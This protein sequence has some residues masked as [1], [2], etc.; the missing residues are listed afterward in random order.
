MCEL[1][2]FFAPVLFAKLDV[3]KTGLVSRA[4]FGAF[5]TER[6]AVADS[7]ER[8]FE[9]LRQGQSQ[10]LRQSDFKPLLAALLGSHPGLEFLKD[11]PEFQE[12]YVETVIYRIF[13]GVDRSNTGSVSLRELKRSALLEAMFAVD[14]EEDINKVLKF[15]SYE[16]FYVIY[17]KFWEL[18]TDHDFLIDKDDL[19]RYGNH[20][21][22]YRI[23][24]RIL[25]QAGRPFTSGTE[26]KMGY[27]DFVW[28][29]LVRSRA[30]TLPRLR[31]PAPAQDSAQF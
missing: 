24:D 25:A 14:E 23:V 31:A 9:V 2:G 3:G 16:H 6:M 8:A 17:C 30:R 27:E 10:Y 18:D 5:W 11:A 12:R 21:L 7:A 22:T 29:V 1:P 20:A 4:Q 15:F 13:Y 19:L 26:G 28:F